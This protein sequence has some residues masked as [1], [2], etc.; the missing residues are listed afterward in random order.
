[1]ARAISRNW[2][3]GTSA[4]MPNPAAS[5]R[6]AVVIARDARGEA[7]ATASRIGRRRAS[8]QIRPTTNTL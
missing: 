6:P 3:S 8:S 1:M 2:A 7:T 5:A 4:S